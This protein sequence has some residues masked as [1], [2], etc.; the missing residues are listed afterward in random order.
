M[1]DQRR[2][3]VDD[4]A[5][6]LYQRFL[7]PTV[8]APW[9]AVLVDRV[10]PRQGERLLDVACGTRVVARLAAERVGPS[11]RVTALDINARMLVVGRSLPPVAGA[12]IDW[13]EGS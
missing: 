1:D 3:Q 13:C 8:T 6:E 7:V 2:W 9:A 4:D 11:G 5:A 12:V 10:A